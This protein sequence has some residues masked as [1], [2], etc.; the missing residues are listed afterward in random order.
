MISASCRTQVYGQKLWFSVIDGKAQGFKKLCTHE[1][2]KPAPFRFTAPI[3]ISKME[4]ITHEQ[5]QHLLNVDESLD[6]EPFQ[7]FFDPALLPVSDGDFLCFPPLPPIEEEESPLVSDIPL[8]EYDDSVHSIATS[9]P[10]IGDISMFQKLLDQHREKQEAL[11][12]E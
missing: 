9:V 12:L 11:Q 2:K 1:V 3:L 8:L 6:L 4:N 7:S 10:D 5:F